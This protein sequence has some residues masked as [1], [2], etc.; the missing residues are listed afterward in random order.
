MPHGCNTG[1]R[2][3]H[4]K[5]QNGMRMLFTISKG[6]EDLGFNSGANSDVEKRN[7]SLRVALSTQEGSLM[8]RLIVLESR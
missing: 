3:M 4:K 5:W 6:S 7:I 8:F 1:A 2:E